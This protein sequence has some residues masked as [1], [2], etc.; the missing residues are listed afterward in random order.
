MEFKQIFKKKVPRCYLLRKICFQKVKV[1]F[2]R[3]TLIEKTHFF[4]NGVFIY[5]N[6]EFYQQIIYN[7]RVRFCHF[8]ELM[9]VLN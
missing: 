1:M 6:I 5:E 8:L 3:V 4:S 9:L 7:Y 2:L